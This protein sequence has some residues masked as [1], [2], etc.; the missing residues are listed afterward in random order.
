MDGYLLVKIP[1]P[2]KGLLP[3]ALIPPDRGFL[4][5][6]SSDDEITVAFDYFHEHFDMFAGEDETENFKQAVEFIQS[7][8]D[9][10]VC[11][12]VVLNGIEWC[13]TTS[14]DAGDKPDLSDWKSLS[15]DCEDVYVRSWYGK[16]NRKYNVQECVKKPIKEIIRKVS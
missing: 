4:N 11:I 6:Y 7:I 13:G 12:V 5:V 2:A 3:E 10:K 1:V 16:Y 15:L 14:L 8:L 9:E